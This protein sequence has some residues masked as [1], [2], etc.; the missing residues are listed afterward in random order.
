MALGVLLVDDVDPI[1]GRPRHV[2]TFESASE[3]L[4]VFQTQ[5]KRT[6]SIER[7]EERRSALWTVL[8]FLSHPRTNLIE[9]VTVIVSWTSV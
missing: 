1:L 7:R 8:C 9:M 4:M 6:S 5:P 3:G 2:F